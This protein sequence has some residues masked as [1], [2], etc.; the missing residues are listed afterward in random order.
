[1]ISDKGDERVVDLNVVDLNGSSAVVSGLGGDLL[2]PNDIVSGERP[3]NH[4]VD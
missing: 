2:M 4:L 1:M 3:E